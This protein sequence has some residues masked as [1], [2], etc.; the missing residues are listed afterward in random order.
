M[1]KEEEQNKRSLRKTT[2]HRGR[3]IDNIEE[4]VNSELEGLFTREDGRLQ[5]ALAVFQSTLT[6][7]ATTE[8]KEDKTRLLKS[9]R[10]QGQCCS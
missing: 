9:F 4:K 3:K 2:K 7:A 5:A 8:K 10:K 6:A 1:K